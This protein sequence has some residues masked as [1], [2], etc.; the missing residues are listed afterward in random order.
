[1]EAA[2]NR[3]KELKGGSVRLLPFRRAATNIL[4]PLISQFRR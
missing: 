1:M 4:F 2:A 3:T